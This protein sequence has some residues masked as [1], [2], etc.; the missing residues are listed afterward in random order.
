[1]TVVVNHNTGALIWAKKGHGKAVLTEFFKELT[2]GQRAMIKLVS[3]GQTT[4]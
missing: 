4:H 1:M 2:E 3:P